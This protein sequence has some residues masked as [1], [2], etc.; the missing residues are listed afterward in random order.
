VRYSKLASSGGHVLALRSD[1]AAIA[2]GDNTYGQASVPP[3]VGGLTYTQVASGDFHSAALRSDGA[4]ITWGTSQFGLLNVPVLPPS[5]RYVAIKAGGSET[6]ALVSAVPQPEVFGYGVGCSG[7]GGLLTLSSTQVPFLGN[8]GFA[9]D[10]T[11]GVPN[12]SSYLFLATQQAMPAIGIG[13]GCSIHLDLVSLL[14]FTQ[15]GVSPIGPLPNNALG[16]AQFAIPVPGDPSLAGVTLYF[17]AAA[18]DQSGPFGLTLSNGL[19]C[20]LN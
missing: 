8:S 2:W 17:Q 18:S 16:S 7:L 9:M 19:V 6:V 4:V 13:G 12:A 14:A 15:A 10:V 1:G 11:Q 3:L 5:H 20:V